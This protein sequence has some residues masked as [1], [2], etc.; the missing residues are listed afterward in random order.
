VADDHQAWPRVPSVQEVA[1]VHGAIKLAPIS[2]RRTVDR[3]DAADSLNRL[4][5]KGSG[6]LKLTD[7]GVHS[8]LQDEGLLYAPRQLGLI[9]RVE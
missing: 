1:D 7:E 3:T 9:E 5:V 6:V 2:E 4:G 8:G